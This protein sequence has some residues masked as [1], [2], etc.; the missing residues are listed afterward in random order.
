MSN[1]KQ[2]KKMDLDAITSGKALTGKMVARLVY[3]DWEEFED[4]SFFVA[5][6]RGVA[7]EISRLSGELAERKVRTLLSFSG[8]ETPGVMVF[9]G[10]GDEGLDDVVL[11]PEASENRFVPITEEEIRGIRKYLSDNGY[12]IDTDTMI[13]ITAN[14]VTFVADT[15]SGKCEISLNIKDFR[16][17]LAAACAMAEAPAPGAA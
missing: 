16:N 4:A 8:K 14:D 9:L 2:S 7:E 10:Y 11:E 6:D 13:E 15:E 1:K 12:F 3:A 17:E 5:L